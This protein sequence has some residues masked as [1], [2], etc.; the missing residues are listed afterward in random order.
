MAGIIVVKA[1]ETQKQKAA[2]PVFHDWECEVSEFEHNYTEPETFLVLQGRAE[3]THSGGT[4]SF[5]AGD[6]VLISKIGN[7]HW[8]VFEKIKKRYKF[9]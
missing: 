5:G 2:T 1:N 4:S 3:I 8:K 6:W 7:A 9:G